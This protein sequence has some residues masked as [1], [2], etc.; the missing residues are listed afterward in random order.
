MENA[1]GN[2]YTISQGD[3]ILLRIDHAL[4]RHP[5]SHL[6]TFI[7]IQKY[8]YPGRPLNFSYL[9][10]DPPFI[11][12]LTLRQNLLLDSPFFKVGPSRQN[13]DEQILKS[14]HPLAQEL[15]LGIQN[16]DVPSSLATKMDCQIVNFIKVLL[17]SKSTLLCESFDD[18]LFLDQKIKIQLIIEEFCHN[19]VVYFL[20]PKDHYKQRISK[21][22]TY[23]GLQGVFIDVLE[24]SYDNKNYSNQLME[25]LK[26]SA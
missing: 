8:L 11:K 22:I 20:D 25:E 18:Q 15:Y 16:F 17:Q 9:A 10:K 2:G 24:E 1:K 13:S 19:K 23:S 26:K 14:L 4:V 5:T 6:R 7:N 21:V 3:K 12:A